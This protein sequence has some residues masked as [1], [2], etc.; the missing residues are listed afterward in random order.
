MVFVRGHAADFDRWEE[1]GA[2]RLGLQADVLP[3]FKRM[4]T[5]HGGEDGWRGT[6]GPLHVTRGPLANPLYHAFTE[7]GAEAGFELHRRLQRRE[8]G[9]L[10][11][12]GDDGLAGPAL[13]G[14]QRLSPPGAEAAERRAADRRASPSASSSTDGRA[15]GVEVARG[16]RRETVARAQGGD[17]LR[18]LDQLA[19]APDAL[20]HRPGGAPAPSTASRCVADR[21]GVG[22][23]LQD[24]LEVYVQQACTAADHAQRASR[25][26]GARAD[27]RCMA[28][29][30]HA[31]SAPRTISRPAPSSAPRAG[32]PYPDLQL[33]FLPAA[34]RYDGRAAATAHGFQ[35]HIG[36]MRSPSR[37]TRAAALAPTRA[38]RRR[39]ASTT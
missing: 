28:G 18:L 27:R 29:L 7:A 5:A 2:R 37:G 30:R 15:I 38:R 6:D 35:V 3:Y 39:S 33:H 26:A 13:V 24:H 22:A 10:R 20:R 16:G 23:N 17:R 31:G 21:P 19:E 4:E 9:R 36:P 12:D 8:A 32:V 14:R 11:A 1:A 34:I 25:A